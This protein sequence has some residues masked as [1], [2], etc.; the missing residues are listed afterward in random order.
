MQC[1]IKIE[2]DELINHQ[3]DG[4]RYNEFQDLLRVYNIPVAKEGWVSADEFADR[5]NRLKIAIRKTIESLEPD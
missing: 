1:P 5:H 4:R 2:G 3:R